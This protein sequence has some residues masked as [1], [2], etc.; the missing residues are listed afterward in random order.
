L[1]P[2]F[3]RQIT[4]KGTVLN[5]A[6]YHCSIKIVSRGKGKSAVAAAAYR[7]GEKITN[8][9][10]GRVSD[11]TRKGGIV[12]KE[13]MLPEHAPEEYSSRSVL[14]NA[15]EKIEKAA[16]SQLAREIELALPVELSRE[17]NI[18]LVREYVKNN[19]VDSGMCADI[20]VHDKKAGNPHAHIMLTM[21]PFNADKSWGIK[22]RKDYALDGN[23]NRIPIIDE[24]TGLQKL[25]GRNR[26]QWKRVYV[27]TNDWN[28]QTKAED[29]RAA[30]ED[31]ANAALEKHGHAE[32]IDHRSYERQGIQQIPTVHMGVAATQMERRGIETECGNMNREISRINQFL[33]SIMTK[34]KQLKDWL[35]EAV[36]PA[37]PPALASILK[38]VLEN[39]E[40]DSRYGKIRNMNKAERVYNYMQENGISKMSE[41][42]DKYSEVHGRYSNA[43]D[44]LRYYEQR[45][46]TLDEHIRQGGI[47]NK[48]RELYKEYKNL[49]PRKQPKF[50]ETHHTDLMLFEAARRYF[51]EQYISTDF[52]IKDWKEEKAKLP[53]ERAEV[54]RKHKAAETEFT[55]VENARL[56][57]E[58]IVRE[59]NAPPQRP[60]RSRDWS[61]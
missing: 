51:K 30:W 37:T 52:S 26:K 53:A 17:Q 19:F 21:R 8:E 47:Y 33:S 23:G 24:A 61:R 41:L 18:S 31:A 14:W 28:D 48:H 60:T 10:D 50:Y 35:K 34:L 43:R 42:R 57:A 46:K 40:Q 44:S 29:W 54:Y 45:M 55:T 38:G 25:D 39:G 12:H 9:Y 27:Q 3:A 56:D 59:L 32:R 13:I 49:K 2:F 7:A 4:E 6:I 36:T 5:M 11:Y 20:C 16:N 22:E 15:V 58:Q 1:P